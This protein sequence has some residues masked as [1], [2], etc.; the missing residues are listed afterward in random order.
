MYYTWL[1]AGKLPKRINIDFSTV[2]CGYTHRHLSSLQNTLAARW[3]SNIACKYMWPLI[4]KAQARSIPNP[5][6]FDLVLAYY[7][8]INLLIIILLIMMHNLLVEVQRSGKPIFLV[9][10]VGAASERSWSCSC[11]GSSSDRQ[12]PPVVVDRRGTVPPDYVAEH[13]AGQQA[14]QAD[15]A[16]SYHFRFGR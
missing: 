14:G 5:G 8:V 7:N 2:R 16:A 10:V 15:R 9:L 3:I 13:Q 12:R 6:Y 1:S 4:K 11:R